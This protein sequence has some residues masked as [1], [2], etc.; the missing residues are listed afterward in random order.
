MHCSSSGSHFGPVQ[1]KHSRL[2]AWT[3]SNGH[4]EGV[5]FENMVTVQSATARDLWPAAVRDP[6]AVSCFMAKTPPLL[7]D[8]QFLTIASCNSVKES[9]TR[10]VSGSLYLMHGQI[11]LQQH[12]SH[13]NTQNCKNIASSFLLP[14]R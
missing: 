2:L 8:S 1:T 11:T 10:T 9:R 4:E 7:S 12:M 13:R 3:R 14:I 5:Q 6:Q